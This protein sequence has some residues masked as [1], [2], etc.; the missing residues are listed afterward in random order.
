MSELAPPNEPLPQVRTTQQVSL[1]SEPDVGSSRDAYLQA[2]V[3]GWVVGRADGWAEV[4][5]H[6]FVAEEYLQPAAE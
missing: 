3:I 6:G 1:R 5:V 2:G 4:W